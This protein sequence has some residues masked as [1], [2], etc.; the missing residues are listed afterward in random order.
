MNNNNENNYPIVSIKQIEKKV[1]R[2]YTDSESTILIL[3]KIA[4]L[5]HRSLNDVFKEIVSNFIEN[6]KIFDPDNNKYYE[7]KGIVEKD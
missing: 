1:G 2:T 3:E 4:E 7:V 5:T 6:G